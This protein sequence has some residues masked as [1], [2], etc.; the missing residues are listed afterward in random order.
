ML[1]DAAESKLDVS[2][3][4]C[5]SCIASAC[6]TDSRSLSALNATEGFPYRAHAFL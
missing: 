1:L 3:I 6:V 2:N 5:H 4:G